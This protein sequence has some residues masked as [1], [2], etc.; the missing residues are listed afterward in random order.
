MDIRAMQYYLAVVRE[1]TISGAAEALHVAQPSLSRQ[2]ME[3]ERELGK[4]LFL[5]TNKKTLLTEDGLRLKGRAREILALVER[6]AAE[7]RT[8]PEEIRGNVCFGAGET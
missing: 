8:I 6:T 1:G 2:M 5:R 4:R 7:L 3:L